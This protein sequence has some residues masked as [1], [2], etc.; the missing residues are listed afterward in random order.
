LPIS[1]KLNLWHP[2]AGR[3]KIFS[4]LKLSLVT[5]A[6]RSL[7]NFAQQVVFSDHSSTAGPSAYLLGSG[8]DNMTMMIAGSCQQWSVTTLH[9]GADKV[10]MQ[11]LNAGK[12]A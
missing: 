12:H 8:D 3:E 2:L 4:E 9:N 11:T 7:S 5:F 1:G 6:G 10:F